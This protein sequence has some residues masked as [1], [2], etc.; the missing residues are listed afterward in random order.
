MF[1]NL[2]VKIGNKIV[3]FSCR[4]KKVSL[5]HVCY[6]K[7]D[8]GQIVEELMCLIRSPIEIFLRHSVTNLT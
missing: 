3:I 7:L 1:A 4:R 8:R 6:K 2:L 5:M